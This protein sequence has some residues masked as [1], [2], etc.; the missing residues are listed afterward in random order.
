MAVVA[1]EAGPRW[2]TATPVTGHR[3]CNPPPTPP[4]G[5]RRVLNTCLVH[6]SLDADYPLPDLRLAIK[7]KVHSLAIQSPDVIRRPNTNDEARPSGELF[8]REPMPL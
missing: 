3:F 6:H 7:C 4:P 5:R 8:R 2:L 1:L